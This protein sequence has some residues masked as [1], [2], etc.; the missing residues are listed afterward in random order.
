MSHLKVKMK[1]RVFVHVV[2][3][4]VPRYS[5]CTIFVGHLTE[6]CYILCAVRTTTF[7]VM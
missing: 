3:S 6:T 5:S 2:C 4:C 7:D 1:S